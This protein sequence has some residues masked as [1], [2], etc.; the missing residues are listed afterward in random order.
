MLAANLVRLGVISVWGGGGEG[1]YRCVDESNRKRR[2]ACAHTEGG[3]EEKAERR[4]AT[5][6]RKREHMIRL[7][8]HAMQPFYPRSKYLEL[9]LVCIVFEEII[10]PLFVEQL[11]GL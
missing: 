8:F 1:V 10:S 9:S 7:L 6:R 2:H 11:L 5:K 4:G 3:G